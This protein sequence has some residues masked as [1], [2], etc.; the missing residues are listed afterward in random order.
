LEIDQSTATRWM[1]KMIEDVRKTQFEKSVL[2]H[3]S[4][5]QLL[6]CGLCQR[7]RR[8]VHHW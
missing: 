2:W 5:S 3:W 6:V 7:R 1:K 4:L 8:D